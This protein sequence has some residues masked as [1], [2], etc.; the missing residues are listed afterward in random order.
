VDE[1]IAAGRRLDFQIDKRQLDGDPLL[2]IAPPENGEYNDSMVQLE[3]LE[4]RDGQLYLAGRTEKGARPTGPIAR[5]ADAEASQ[6]ARQ[7]E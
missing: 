2:L 4:L 3:A 6:P 1:L 7:T 5:R